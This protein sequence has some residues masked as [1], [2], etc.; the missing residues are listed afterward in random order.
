M[1]TCH[2]S[3]VLAIFNL[4]LVLYIIRRAE[5]RKVSTEATDRM[6]QAVLKKHTDFRTP[7]V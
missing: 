6:L 5:K 7:R 4:G 3:L 1:A 2:F